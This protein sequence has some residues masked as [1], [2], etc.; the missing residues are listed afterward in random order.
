MQI[1]EG[2]ENY[3]RLHLNNKINIHICEVA[4]TIDGKVG[5]SMAP[6]DMTNQEQI[7]SLIRFLQDKSSAANQQVAIKPVPQ[8]IAP[9]RGRRRVKDE[10]QE[11][12]SAYKSSL[13]SMDL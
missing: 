13:A 9:E 11:V 3:F 5:I 6:I 10:I 8:A 12:A 1:N 7:S 4:F 2:M